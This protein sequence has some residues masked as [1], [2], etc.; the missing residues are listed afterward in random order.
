MRYVP[1]LM[2]AVILGGIASAPA[3]AGSLSAPSASA[4]RSLSRYG[5]EDRLL[6]PLLQ[7]SRLHRPPSQRNGRRAPACGE[8]G[9]PGDHRHRAGSPRELRRVPLLE[10]LGL[11]RCPLQQPLCRPALSATPKAWLRW[12][13]PARRRARPEPWVDAGDA[14]EIRQDGLDLVGGELDLRHVAVPRAH[15]FGE[16]FLELL[17]RIFEIDL[18]ERRRFRQRALAGRGDG[19]AFGAMGLEK[20][21]PGAALVSSSAAS[22]PAALAASSATA[23][24]AWRSGRGLSTVTPSKSHTGE[25]SPELPTVLLRFSTA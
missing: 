13:L 20:G 10:R 1:A 4:F 23:A 18:P 5:R 2:T 11:R 24:K 16:T 19:M 21:L 8:S 7:I 6:A 9:Q 14:A 12:G 22:A 3:S 17:D 15:A 25:A